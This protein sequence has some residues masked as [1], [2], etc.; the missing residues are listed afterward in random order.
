M[1]CFWNDPDHFTVNRSDPEFFYQ[2][3][4]NHSGNYCGT[5]NSVHVEALQPEHFLYPEPRHYLS[6]YYKDP[7]QQTCQ[8][9]FNI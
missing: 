5:D 6:F 9:K 1:V 8:K 2:L 3:K 4:A 7:E